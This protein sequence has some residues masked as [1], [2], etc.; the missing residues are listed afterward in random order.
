[1]QLF[2]CEP[3]SRCINDTLPL[4]FD[5][6][7]R[8][9]NQRHDL[10]GSTSGGLASRVRHI[11]GDAAVDLVADPREHGHRA[12]RDRAGDEGVVERSE[13]GA[14]TAASRKENHVHRTPPEGAQGS[15]HR[16]RGRRPL[17]CGVDGDHGKPEA[18]L[19]EL[20]QHIGL[21]SA[22]LRGDQPD[23]QR[24]CGD[25]QL[26]VGVEEP[27]CRKLRQQP[28]TVRAE[29]TQ[30][31]DR[32][33]SGHPQAEITSAN[34]PLRLA[35]DPKL[36]PLFH[37]DGRPRSAQRGVDRSPIV[38]P[39]HHMHGCLGLIVQPGT[40]FDE[41]EEQVAL[42][43]ALDASPVPQLAVQP[44]LVGM[45]ALH[46][47][48]QRKGKLAHRPRA[49]LHY[50]EWQLLGHGCRTYS[51]GATHNRAGRDHSVHPCDTWPMSEEA[52]VAE[53]AALRAVLESVSDIVVMCDDGGGI[54]EGSRSIWAWLGHDPAKLCGRSV[55]DILDLRPETDWPAALEVIQS[56]AG[57]IGPIEAQAIAADGGRRPVL[58][59]ARRCSPEQGEDDGAEDR[60]SAPAD[61][62]HRVARIVVAAR[63]MTAV[64][65]A[66]RRATHETGR[67][68][69]Q[70]QQMRDITDLLE[71]LGRGAPMTETLADLVTAPHRWLPGCVP[72]VG[73]VDDT[74]RLRTVPGHRLPDELSALL[75]GIEPDSR[76]GQMWR[77]TS[78]PVLFR[79]LANDPDWGDRGRAFAK[80]GLCAGWIW[81]LRADDGQMLGALGVF[82]PERRLP[83][84]EE[85]V[86]FSHAAYL[87]VIIIQRHLAEQELAHRA[88]HDT[89]TGLP[90]RTLLGDRIRQGVAMA[91]RS[92]RRAAVLC[93]D[94]DRFKVVN[95]SLGH[96]AGDA[97]LR[98]I[99]HRFEGVVRVG[100]TVGR[101]GGDEFVVVANDVEDEAEVKAL[102]RRLVAALKEPLEIDGVDIVI[103]AS[104]GVAITE[105]G[106]PTDAELLIRDADAAMYQAKAGRGRVVVFDHPMRKSIVERL[107][108]ET[109]LRRAVRSNELAV[110]YQPIVRLDD[111]AVVGC[112]A[113]V[114]WDRPGYGLTLPEE[115]VGVAEQA[116]LIGELGTWV[117]RDVARQAQEWS[118][119]PNL[120][121][122]RI[123]TNVSAH[124]LIEPGLVDEIV[125]LLRAHELSPGTLCLE[126]TESLLI[127]DAVAVASVIR[128]LAAVGINVAIDDFGSGFTS[129]EYARRFT[130]V[131]GLK[132]DA[133][134]VVDLADSDSKSRA[135]VASLAVLG[136]GLGADV[137]AE[138]VETEEQCAILRELGCGFAQGYLFGRPMT[139]SAFADYVD[140]HA[141]AHQRPVPGTTDDR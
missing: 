73:V 39:Q 86:L 58:L 45:S 71:R 35:A 68:E 23:A 83:N 109:D 55:G 139:A 90:N 97:L 31:E 4:P 136:R 96:L 2:R 62:G 61:N 8:F 44:E 74:G 117:L 21:C 25:W 46:E 38:V 104:V 75:D 33:D 122:V 70:A 99:G 135:I 137:T 91:E 66:T 105:A 111:R 130:S 48:V 132:I 76:L 16:T 120:A 7:A 98:E 88:L 60:A 103:G 12:S 77:V 19:L 129:L 124:Q 81:G 69:R 100:D 32:I 110:A 119:N 82:V 37:A 6:F 24:H 84:E 65:D 108:V 79:D 128:R 15:D 85:H 80:R 131:S 9:A 127:E 113:L 133:A 112:E 94:L 138:G 87:A 121:T 34:P 28:V 95:D 116:G 14:G 78:R 64:E 49:L 5:P 140:G 72:V 102:A 123:S 53:A 30:G 63:D 118:S 56:S 101:F 29:A 41:V 126:V 11:V 1:M 20:A 52:P 93:C 50:V 47:L 26:A 51:P 10:R 36:D 67:S 18:T 89:L 92:G 106:Q 57:S 115:F 42:A 13:V 141:A 59:L 40:G 22:S 107:Q 43:V 27:C 114:R 54:L 3:R 17:H 125:S 134:F